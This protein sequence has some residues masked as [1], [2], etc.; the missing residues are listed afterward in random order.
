MGTAWDLHYEIYTG[1]PEEVTS[2]IFIHWSCSYSN[3]INSNLNGQS[4]YTVT[5][6]NIIGLGDEGADNTQS[7]EIF[8][9]SSEIC[10]QFS[11]KRM[12]QQL[13]LIK[14]YSL[15]IKQG[16]ND[17]DIQLL[18]MLDDNMLEKIG[19][20]KMAHRLRIISYLQNPVLYM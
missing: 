7:I 4:K 12:L 8:I 15:F 11:L 14:Y 2:D 10:P 6:A 3:I 18:V 20:N 16:F 5:E 13:N 19:I 9:E 17:D 1:Y